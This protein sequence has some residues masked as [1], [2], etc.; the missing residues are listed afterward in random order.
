MKKLLIFPL[1]ALL[2]AACTTTV[3]VAPEENTFDTA[4]LGDTYMV[5][6]IITTENHMASIY[7]MEVPSTTEYWH[8]SSDGEWIPDMDLISYQL[9]EAI[10]IPEEYEGEVVTGKHALLR[11]TQT[12]SK[13]FP[14]TT[15]DQFLKFINACWVN[16]DFNSWVEGL[17]PCSK[18]ETWCKHVSGFFISCLWG[19]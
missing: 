5:E 9:A 6:V 10:D 7:S 19:Y 11:S 18:G 12:A 3:E 8:L 15:Q 13:T 1:L 14:F 2:F 16:G 17:A 4:E